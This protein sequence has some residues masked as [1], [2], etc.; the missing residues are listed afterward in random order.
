MNKIDH[1]I[2]LKT[3]LD[4]LFTEYHQRFSDHR[5]KQI[6]KRGYVF[7]EVNYK[8]DVLIMGINP[9]QRTD[10]VSSNGFSYNFKDLQEDRYF[11]KLHNL[12][13]D[14]D[15]DV[16]Y[17]DLFYQKHSEQKEI[18]YFL[19]STLGKGFLKDQLSLTKSLITK[20]S[21]KL[22]LLFNRKAASFFTP[23]WLGYQIEDLKED[24]RFRESGISNLHKIKGTNTY[25]YF[26]TFI[27]YRTRKE[28]LFKIQNDVP[29]LLEL[30][31]NF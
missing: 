18:D 28:A 4:T 9:S 25:I 10:F 1:V 31:K 30:C 19:S 20:I 11:K 27:G 12:L 22:I 14:F 24:S 29:I 3:K 2:A 15:R 7:S 26:S 6:V 5:L 21:P 23:E 16:T 13:I 17:C 8:A